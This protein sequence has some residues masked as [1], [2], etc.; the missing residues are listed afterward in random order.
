MFRILQGIIVFVAS[1]L[2]GNTLVETRIPIKVSLPLQA[3]ANQEFNNWGMTTGVTLHILIKPSIE[4]GYS[5]RILRFRVGFPVEESAHFYSPLD[6]HCLEQTTTLLHMIT[7]DFLFLPSNAAHLRIGAGW[8][9][10]CEE[11]ASYSR[12]EQ[13]YSTS[14]S[15]L[16]GMG[17]EYQVLKNLAIFP[18]VELTYIHSHDT[19]LTTNY[20]SHIMAGFSIVFN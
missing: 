4:V 1:L 2:A 11:R 20:Q 18:H 17:Y 5:G 19:D 3:Y 14:P 7:S 6:Y 15:L 9:Y 13:S 8:S 16:I 12:I 10:S